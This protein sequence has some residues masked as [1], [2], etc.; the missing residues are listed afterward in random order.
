M[1]HT[2]RHL[3]LT[4]VRSRRE[5]GAGPALHLPRR[6]RR[7]HPSRVRF[8]HAAGAS[9]ALAALGYLAT[10]KAEES[11]PQGSAG[12]LS[13]AAEVRDVDLY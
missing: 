10:A 3:H 8:V 5:S 12:V 9:L 7:A 4:R 2:A 11:M 13:V 6:P 1:K